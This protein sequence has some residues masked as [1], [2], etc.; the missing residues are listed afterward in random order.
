MLG[1]AEWARQSVGKNKTARYRG[2]VRGVMSHGREFYYY[3]EITLASQFGRWVGGERGG[4]NSAAV[5]E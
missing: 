2:L 5:P 4:A 1:R 3:L